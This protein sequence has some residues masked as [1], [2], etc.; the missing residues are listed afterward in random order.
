MLMYLES[1]TLIYAHAYTRATL[2]STCTIMASSS[3]SKMT[4]SGSKA[5]FTTAHRHSYISHS[6][7][8]A[9][10]KS[11]KENGLPDSISRR[12]LKRARQEE[13]GGNT[14][15][16][17]LITHISL[18]L[19]DGSVK[20]FPV[21][22]PLALFWM[23]LQKCDAFRG[24]FLEHLQS[25]PSNLNNMWRVALYNDEVLPGNP[26]KV[27]NERKIM[28]FYWSWMEYGKFIHQE[29]MWYHLCAIRS[30][31]I[32]KVKGGVSQ[33]FKKI[34]PLFFSAPAD[35]RLGVQMTLPPGPEGLS[36]SLFLFGCFGTLVA[37]EVALKQCWSFKG[38]SG[39]LPCFRCS[40]VV[41]HSS[42]LDLHDSS[43]TLVPSCVV[44]FA[45]CRLHTNDSLKG[46]A[47]HLARQFPILNK[48]QFEKLEQSLGLTYCPDG[49][50][51]SDSCLEMVNG[52]V[53]C[54]SFD[55]MHCYLVS[56]IWNSEVGLL[57]DSIQGEISS[58][59]IH[60]FL[61]SLTWPTKTRASGMTGRKAFEKRTP[62]SG[63]LA[64]SASE[65]LSLYPILKCFIADNLQDPAGS[66]AFQSYLALC[67]VLDLLQSSRQGAC[68][69]A[70]LHSAVERHLGHRLVAHG[71]NSFQPKLHYSLHLAG[72][73]GL[74][75]VL[76]ACWCH[77]RK[78]KELKRYAN[79]LH[80]A[81][82]KM[83]WEKSLLQ[84]VL[85][86][87][88]LHLQDWTPTAEV[89]LT[90]GGPASHALI[91]FLCSH[92]QLRRNDVESV[93]VSE[94]ALI[95]YETFGKG[96]AIICAHDDG[97]SVVAELWFHMEIRLADSSCVHLSVISV[98][99]PLP[100]SNKTYRMHSD[101]SVMPTLSIVK[102]MPFLKQ[103]N[104]AMLVL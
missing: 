5:V 4:S 100:G 21:V 79:N 54:T 51:W 43:G 69:A 8:I 77:E 103:G 95:R 78:H 13:L 98:W 45:S 89:S 67:E 9:T 60:A 11:V 12:T 28:G 34:V 62:G 26:L 49:A 44:S 52:I 25:K 36:S 92:W 56:G 19:T 48:S 6:G 101:P 88:F 10:L 41:A 97:T 63:M 68:G 83:A 81:N 87:Q 18:D 40:N 30:S 74:H 99:T 27:S 82:P 33:L 75:K 47:A 3:S 23:V 66:Y 32:R 86:L 39:T 58:N 96:D 2:N 59:M 14:P 71:P 24:W 61:S 38:S 102:S 85:L 31:H 55:W 72:Q 22:H 70:A 76:I 93:H 90:G 53:D 46:N 64:V 20:Q 50:L 42:R 7:L 15:F 84:E 65:G 91:E 16:G 57:M 94:N 80:N 29:C 37:D 104:E 35:L 73:L 17:D 1:N